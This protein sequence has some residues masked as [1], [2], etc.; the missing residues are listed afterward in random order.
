MVLPSESSDRS[1]KVGGGS[2]TGTGKAP[3]YREAGLHTFLHTQLSGCNFLL[4]LPAF[5]I[6]GRCL[7]LF[8]HFVVNLDTLEQEKQV[9]LWDEDQLTIDHIFNILAFL[10]SPPRTF[11][12]EGIYSSELRGKHNFSS[13]TIFEE[14]LT[15]LY[16]YMVFEETVADMIRSQL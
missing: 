6:C 12:G 9:A 14:G 15:V 7:L 3:R 11:R 5:S 8:L 13:K 1:G 4:L 2:A 16:L 10:Y